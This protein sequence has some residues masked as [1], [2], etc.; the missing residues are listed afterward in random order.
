[1]A[2]DKYVLSLLKFEECIRDYQRLNTLSLLEG[3]F[4]NAEET[5]EYVPS[6]GGST[7]FLL[8]NGFLL[9]VE[10]LI[11]NWRIFQWMKYN[12]PKPIRTL[13]V[14]MLGLPV[15]HWFVDPYSMSNFFQHG[16]LAFFMILPIDTFE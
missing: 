3:I 7:A 13:L 16:Q 8:W 1:M 12:L 5:G 9:T 11:W 15:A 2:I 10:S 6:F 14:I 4:Y